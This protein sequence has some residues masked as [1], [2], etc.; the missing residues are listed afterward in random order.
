MDAGK[1]AEKLFGQWGSAG[2]HKSA[3]R[4][5]IPIQKLDLD[6]NRAADFGEFVLKRIK[7]SRKRK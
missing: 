4:A 3:A 6:P 2:G 7:G 1:A 5:E